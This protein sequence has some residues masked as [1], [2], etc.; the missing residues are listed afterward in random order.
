MRA[1]SSSDSRV[2]SVGPD[3]LQRLRNFHHFERIADGEAQRLVHVGDQR[4]HA[5]V[6][7]PSDAHHHLRQTA[8]VDLLLHERAGAHL[9]VQHQR[10]DA[11]GHLARHDGGGHQAGSIRRW[12]WHRAARTSGR[13]PARSPRVQPMKASLCSFNCAMNSSERQIRA[14]PGNRFQLI[15][16]AAGE[17]QRAAPGHGHD[18]SRGRGQ[19]RRDQAGLIADAAGRVLI[20]FDAGNAG[21]IERHSRSDHALGQRADFAVGHAGKVRAMRNADI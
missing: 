2:R 21:Q 13:R 19:R 8:R 12:P 17:A 7:A 14:E 10:V 16:R 20:D 9:H 3:V 6:H 1:A 5:L 15:E 11:G 18:D 4:L